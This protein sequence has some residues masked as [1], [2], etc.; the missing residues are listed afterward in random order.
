MT[1]TARR[2]PQHA[3]R[4]QILHDLRLTPHLRV[5]ELAIRFGVTPETIRRDLDMLEGEGR[6]VRAHGGASAP[7][8][9]ARPDLEARGRARL[10]ERSRIGRLAAARVRPGDTVM[11]DAGSTT[12]EMARHLALAGTACTVVTNAVHV[13]MTLGRSEAA[14]VI[15]C[16]GAYLSQEAATVGPDAVEF[17]S[18]HNVAR[19]FIGASALS[20]D[21]ASEI[22]PGFAAIKRAMIARAGE[23]YLLADATKFGLTHLDRIGGPEAFAAV[24]TDMRPEAGL[25]GRLVAAGLDIEIAP[26]GEE[27]PDPPSDPEPRALPAGLGEV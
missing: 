3:R 6:V 26:G 14:R 20:Q 2:P 24:L 4:A 22:V 13:A 11:I 15:L 18:R 7:V 25:A 5:A 8:A 9:G 21:G 16:P 27:A 1:D 17:L 10:A 23:A 12:F 19:C